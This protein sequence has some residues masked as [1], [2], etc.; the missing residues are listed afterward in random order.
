QSFDSP[1]GLQTHLTSHPVEANNARTT[2]YLNN[3]PHGRP[4]PDDHDELRITRAKPEELESLTRERDRWQA[5]LE[6]YASYGDK[7]NIDNFNQRFN[8]FINFI[9]KAANRLINFNDNK[10]KQNAKN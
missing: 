5:Q 2:S 8:G 1:N 4:R 9:S 3:H 6:I 7:A 10:A